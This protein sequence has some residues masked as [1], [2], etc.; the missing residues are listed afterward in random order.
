MEPRADQ[1]VLDSVGREVV[2]AED[3]SRGP[4]Q[5]LEPVSDQKLESVSIAPCGS[6]D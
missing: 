1:G 6:N 3:Q 4:V 2:G 5:S